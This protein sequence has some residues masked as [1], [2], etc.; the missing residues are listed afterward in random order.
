VLK[1][2]VGLEPDYSEFFFFFLSWVFNPGDDL[3]TGRTGLDHI[4]CIVFF[5][6]FGW[7]GCGAVFALV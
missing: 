7:L 4:I 1:R 6:R 2:L 3:F 5:R